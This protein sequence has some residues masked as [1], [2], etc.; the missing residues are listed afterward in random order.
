[1]RPKSLCVIPAR[2][3]SKGILNKNITK[4]GNLTLLAKTIIQAKESKD[5]DYIHVSTDSIDIQK[6]AS[7][8][9]ATARSIS[10]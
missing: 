9:L 10:S 3:G 1:M 2:G 6:E 5:F 4:L 7:Q 8:S